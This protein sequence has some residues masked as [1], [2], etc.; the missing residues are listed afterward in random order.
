MVNFLGIDECL[1]APL[2]RESPSALEYTAA[3]FWVRESYGRYW[4]EQG[5][6][7]QLITWQLERIFRPYE[8]V[9]PILELAMSVLETDFRNAF[10][11]SWV[12]KFNS[13]LRKGASATDL[14][15]LLK[16]APTGGALKPDMMGLSSQ[17]ALIFDAV[18]VGTEKTARS[19][20][21]ELNSKIRILRDAA[22]PQIKLRLPALSLKFAKGFTSI[23]IP[24]EFEARPSRFR[25]QPWE[26]IL[27]LPLSISKSGKATTADWICYHPSTT[28]RPVDA[29]PSTVD[30]VDGLILYHIHQMA[31]PDL[32]PALRRHFERE[33]Q[34][35]RNAQGLTLEL[36]PALAVALRESRS[37]WSPEAQQLFGYVGLGALVIMIVA[38]G[39]E[40]GLIAEA[41]LAAKAGLVALAESPAAITSALRATSLIARQAW[42]TVVSSAPLLPLASQ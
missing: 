1:N 2:R 37:D 7:P 32:P 4:R 11:V 15:D 17:R 27:P 14:I 12:K 3:E 16:D 41:G 6:I 8:V 33:L 28:Y 9:D 26:R 35:W 23:S 38:V 40:L 42:P 39:W 21:D 19:T 34:R 31:L 36:N 13:L 5:G 24:G 10:P 22:I 30:G 25:L 29:P 20:Y 18:E